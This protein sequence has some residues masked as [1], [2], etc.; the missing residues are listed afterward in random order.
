MNTLY[1]G[2]PILDSTLD[3]NPIKTFI[4][5]EEYKYSALLSSLMDGKNIRHVTYNCLEG[6]CQGDSLVVKGQDFAHAVASGVINFSPSSISLPN[7]NKIGMIDIV[8]YPFWFS[9]VNSIDMSNENLFDT[10]WKINHHILYPYLNLLRYFGTTYTVI[11]CI[12][13]PIDDAP[14]HNILNFEKMNNHGKNVQNVLSE[15]YNGLPN[16]VIVNSKNPFMD[17]R[18]VYMT[19]RNEDGLC[20]TMKPLDKNFFLS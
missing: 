15:I 8:T 6:N 4:V 20:R 10:I 5:D 14:T 11:H 13:Q 16:K 3:T 17:D 2:I 19:R 12:E 7:C 18:Y 1:P 9:L